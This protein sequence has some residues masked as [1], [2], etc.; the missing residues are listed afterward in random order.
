MT[1]RLR[2]RN[3]NEGINERMSKDAS[4]VKCGVTRIFE[5]ASAKTKALAS[6][7]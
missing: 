3:M 1:D 2:Y 6:K 5:I 7:P 4:E